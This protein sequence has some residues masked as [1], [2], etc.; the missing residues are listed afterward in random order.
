V[1]CD[2]GVGLMQVMPPTADFINTRFEKSYDIDDP[3]DNATLGANYLAWLTKAFGDAY[4]KG[5]YDL[6]AS[7]CRSHSSMCLLNM[8]IAGYNVGRQPVD[9]GYADKQLPNP[10]Y[11]GVVRSLMKSCYC[12]RY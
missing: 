11:V 1:A 3:A 4:F 7:K 6:S 10:E 8:V 9:D 12:D 5:K 2:G